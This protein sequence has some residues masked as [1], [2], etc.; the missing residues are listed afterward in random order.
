MKIVNFLQK[1]DRSLR[2]GAA[3]TA[4]FLLCGFS[5]YRIS[6][7]TRSHPVIIKEKKSRKSNDD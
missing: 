1:F 6:D 4:F 7:A 5:V 3:V 2:Y